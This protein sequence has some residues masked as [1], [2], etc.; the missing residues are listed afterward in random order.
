MQFW[1]DLNSTGFD[2]IARS[3]FSQ[4]PLSNSWDTHIEAIRDA[5]KPSTREELELFIGKA[6][7]YSSFIPDLA[8]K[9]RPLRDMIL[10]EPFKW[11]PIADQAYVELKNILISPQVLIPYDP[12]LPLLPATDASKTGL[13][14][15][16]SHRLMQWRGTTDRMRQ[17]HNDSNGAAVS[18]N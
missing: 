1:G 13:G 3:V 12:S 15:V 7:Y 2:L 6:T 9:A 18:H 16:L 11:S 8:T 10:V 4:P 17:S 5:P 14:A